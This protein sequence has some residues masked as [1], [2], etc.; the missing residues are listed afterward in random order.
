LQPENRSM[1][2]IYTPAQNVEIQGRLV[3]VLRSNL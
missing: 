1:D 2:P 3:A